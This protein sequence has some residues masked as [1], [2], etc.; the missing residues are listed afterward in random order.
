MVTARITV[1]PDALIVAL[2]SHEAETEWVLDLRTGEVIPV[3]N[4]AIT[5]DSTVQAELEQEPERYL[6]IEPISSREGRR[7]MEGFAADVPPGL[8]RRRLLAALDGRHPFRD[9]KSVL[10]A[11]PA[12]RAQWFRYHDDRMRSVAKNWLS[13]HELNATLGPGPTSNRGV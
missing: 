8:A 9:F 2:E 6:P 11:F 10:T 5:G 1:D 7:I 3:I 4:P 12:L 13:D